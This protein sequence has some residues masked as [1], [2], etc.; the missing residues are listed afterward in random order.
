MYDYTFLCAMPPD[1][2]PAW[3]K[4]MADIVKPGGHLICLEFPLYKPLETGGPPWGV[5]EELFVELLGD[6]FD[7]V[8]R[9]MPERTHKIGEGH[10]HISI[11]KRKE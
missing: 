6:K 11:W 3:G 8:K 5:K 9:F 10:D 4:R 2:R 7:R 1:L